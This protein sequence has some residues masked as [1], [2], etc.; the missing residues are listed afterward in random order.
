M[1]H[2][3]EFS[4]QWRASAHEAVPY[5][6][7][8]PE[9][10]LVL[11]ELIDGAIGQGSATKINI[12]IKFID[13][14]S[15]YLKVTDNGI[16][17]KNPKRL[18]NWA[19][20]ESTTIHHRYGHGSKKCL[21]KW[22][23]N[24]D[25]KWYVKYRYFQTRGVSSLFQYS[26]PFKGLDT[27]EKIDD[28]NE[29]DLMPSGLEW[30]IEF[31][32]EILNNKNTLKDTFESIKEIIR[33]RYSRYHY[34]KT[35]F[36]VKVF[37]KKDI[38]EESSKINKWISF[39]EAIKK[40]IDNKNC[41]EIYNKEIKFNT[42]TKTTYK[43]YF[44]TIYGGKG[45]DLKKEFQ[46]YGHK[47]MN[48]SR[49][50]ISLNQRV[51]E[52]APFWKFIKDRDANHNSLNGI[53]AFINFENLD[54]LD[55]N[56]QDIYIDNLPTPCTTKVSFYENCKNFIKIKEI[57]CDLNS[58]II[59]NIN[60]QKNKISSEFESGSEFESES[61]LSSDSEID[62]KK[63]KKK[64]KNNKKNNNE[65]AN[66]ESIQKKTNNINNKTVSKHNKNIL[67]QNEPETNFLNMECSDKKEHNNDTNKEEI[68]NDTNR[69]EINNDN[70]TRGRTSISRNLREIIWNRYIGEDI[71]K[72]RCCCCKIRYIRNTDFHAGHII[73]QSKG[74][75]DTIE[76]LRPI[77]S[78]CN[79]GM[80]TINMIDYIKR[81]EFYINN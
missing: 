68:N 55:N 37:D 76:N 15:G 56:K 48:C 39:E 69:E 38:I 16:G 12:E 10:F 41:I 8:F 46:T 32:R 42:N 60:N 79:L 1:A 26:S 65:N 13:D 22:N 4:A 50:Y 31:K 75:K 81:H 6:D 66:K 9:C 40:E 25:C 61:K 21:T 20:K 29:T 18:L 62:I 70:R 63:L 36:I 23:K 28:I 17:V 73:A 74:G 7:D 27:I 54:N 2:I 45:F 5:T 51:I 67:K 52:V 44:L 24:Y 59:K 19:S 11:P 14:N 77:C 72:H 78:Q 33:T 58:E 30:Y 34:D 3:D 49:I 80:G 47:N 71:I 53:F 57:L 35:E 64:V 43:V